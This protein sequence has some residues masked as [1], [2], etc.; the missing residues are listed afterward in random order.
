MT[1]RP[2]D[3]GLVLE[4]HRIGGING[5]IISVT[6]RVAPIHSRIYLALIDVSQMPKTVLLSERS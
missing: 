5:T 6:L 2:V 4:K 1:K 3:I